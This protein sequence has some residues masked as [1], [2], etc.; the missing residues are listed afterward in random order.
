MYIRIDPKIKT[1]V[2]SIYARY[3]MSLTDAI[4]IFIYQSRNVN[5][6]PFDLRDETPNTK[7]CA[8]MQE[9]EDMI[10]GKAPKYTMPVKDF[11]AE[12][13]REVALEKSCDE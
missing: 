1:E 12:I 5:G 13:E 4:N 9:V 10:A 3:G 7:T 8:A 6:L 2:E 11:F